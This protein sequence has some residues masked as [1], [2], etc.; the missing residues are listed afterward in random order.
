MRVD[1]AD[2]AENDDVP[3]SAI[4]FRSLFAALPSPYMV[5]DRDLR[6]VEANAAY[7]AVVER[8]REAMVGRP[9][10]ELFPE[11][12]E[13]GERL[14][15]SL[16]HVLATGRSDTLGLLPYPI[17]RPE[18]RGGGMEMR[19]WTVVHTP[20]TDAAG[21]TQFIVQNTVDVTGLARLKDMAFGLSEPEPGEKDILQR[22]M[23]VEA[24]HRVLL[25]EAQDL[26]ALFMQAPGF[27]AMLEGPDLRFVLANHAYMRL[28]GDRPVIGLTVDDALPELRDQGF[29]ALLRGVMES[30]R[31][32]IGRAM[33]ARLQR[34]SDGTLEERFVDFVYQPVLGAGGEVTGVFVE[35]S[36][37]TD[38]VLAERQQKLLIDELNHRVKNTLAT[39]QAIARQTARATPDPAAFR[40]AFEARLL[41]LSN[42]H[43][44]LTAAGWESASLAD[45]LRSELAPYGAGR[46]RLAGRA[47]AL[48]PAE[49]VALGL[50]FHE[51]ATNAAKHGALS[52]PEGRVEATWT[53]ADAR[54]AL[55]WREH[56]GPRP[57]TATIRRGFGWRLIERSLAG[58]LGGRAVLTLAAG[59]MVCRIELPLEAD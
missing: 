37:I 8:P 28:V 49:A 2:A 38:R 18:H 52:T 29:T 7:C 34:T 39:V 35:G 23:E 30:R 56:G 4:D 32:Y 24:A 53:V 43:N 13:N 33:P 20:L 54:L 48:S 59:G 47:V 50:V 6:M 14:R 5:V 36:D 57:A 17:A 21:R 45:V 46:F 15:A 44:L 19:Y 26:R 1:D 40:I 11:P 12:G 41:A 9:V 16:Q 55:A 3:R 27:M 42:T 22:V 25:G 31:P 51:L 58:Q 10:F